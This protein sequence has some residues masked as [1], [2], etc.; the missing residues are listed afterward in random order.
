MIKKEIDFSEEEIVKELDIFVKKGL[1]EKS[2]KKGKV[3][4]RDSKEVRR[5]LKKGLSRDEIRRK[6]TEDNLK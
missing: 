6:I 5:L 3:Y 2:V 1:L 4:Y